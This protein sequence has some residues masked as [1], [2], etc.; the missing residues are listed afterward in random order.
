MQNRKKGNLLTVIFMAIS[1]TVAGVFSS[2]TDSG[3]FP[4]DSAIKQEGNLP[5][6]NPPVYLWP[7]GTKYYYAFDEKIYL[8]EVENKIVVSFDEK[9]LSDIQL[10]LQKNEQIRH[11]EL[12]YFRNGYIALLV[13]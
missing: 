9:Y 3:I 12:L 4:S 10:Y 7:K 11:M 2:C 13:A 6:D 5:D 1:L 8:N